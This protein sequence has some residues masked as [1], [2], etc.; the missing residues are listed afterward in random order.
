MELHEVV[1]QKIPLLRWNAVQR[2]SELPEE[3]LEEGLDVDAR[4]VVDCDLYVVR[5]QSLRLAYQHLEQNGQE[6]AEEVLSKQNLNQK[7]AE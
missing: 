2:V 4:H 5:K 3:R 6:L 1:E 7:T